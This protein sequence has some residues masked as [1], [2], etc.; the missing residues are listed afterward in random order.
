ME[1]LINI[2]KNQVAQYKQLQKNVLEQRDLLVKLISLEF[3]GSEFQK[4]THK[5]EII[6]SNIRILERNKQKWLVDNKHDLA[7]L[8]RQNVYLSQL[9]NEIM[10]L[11]NNI[12]MLNECNQILL[13]NKM[14]F[15]TF[16]INVL[17][18]TTSNASYQAGGDLPA[19]SLKKIKMFDQSI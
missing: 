5:I 6:M 9:S 1:Y 19:D 11:A 4:Q 16:N 15:I 18:Q 12:K 10:I 7:E 13:K 2:V 17:T 14:D 8:L 3:K